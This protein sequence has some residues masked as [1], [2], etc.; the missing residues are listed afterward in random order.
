MTKPGAS[1]LADAASLQASLRSDVVDRMCVAVANSLVGSK[2]TV[3]SDGSQVLNPL[4]QPV[5][6]AVKTHFSRM[7]PRYALS[8]S[9]A[10]VST[11][12][13][14]LTE[15]ARSKAGTAVHVRNAVDEGGATIDD[16]NEV[17]VV[18][19]DRKCL[20]TAITVALASLGQSIV[21]AD[22]VT[23]TD[24]FAVDR[25]VVTGSASGP[26]EIEQIPLEA[27]VLKSRIEMQLRNSLG[28]SSN[29]TKTKG[30]DEKLEDETLEGSEEGTGSETGSEGSE[31]SEGGDIKGSRLDKRKPSF[32]VEEWS[33][34]FG[35]LKL[36]SKIGSGRSGTTYLAT[37]N[38]N[39]VAAKMMDLKKTKPEA[40]SL[41]LRYI[42]AI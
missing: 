7:P 16:M 32:V 33:I 13:K 10:D 30:E 20:L 31:I 27:K 41:L 24:G 35:D 29:N 4:H 28:V 14:L 36:K 42:I 23:T 38:G 12:M 21:D 39:K 22:I 15:A 34:N 37:Y 18:C 26:S 11:H 17:M 40:V 2:F 1:N 25:F 8:V 19:G 5:F 6:S 3:S 9:I